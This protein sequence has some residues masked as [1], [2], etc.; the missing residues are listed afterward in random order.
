MD[1]DW[2]TDWLNSAWAWL[3]ELLL[4]IPQ[5]LYEL[6]TAGLAA[7]IVAIPVPS[8]AE[9][10]S[11]NWIPNTMAYFLGPMNI[12][13]AITCVTGGLLIRFLIRR[14]PLIG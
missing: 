12:P 10:I 11:L 3:V 14:I 1:W 8:W 4:W 6:V 2:L 13:L 7:V 5:K 9:G